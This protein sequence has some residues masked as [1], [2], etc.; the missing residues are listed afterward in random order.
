MGSSDHF[1][2][3]GYGRAQGRRLTQGA[4]KYRSFLHRLKLDHLLNRRLF[5]WLSS[6]HRLVHIQYNLTV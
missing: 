5:Q 3:L 6:F 2:G 1:F 4:L